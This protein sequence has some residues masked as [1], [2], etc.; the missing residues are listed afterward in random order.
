MQDK[1]R[2]AFYLILTI[3]FIIVGRALIVWRYGSLVRDYEA[4]KFAILK[5]IGNFCAIDLNGI[6]NILI[7]AEDHRHRY[8]FGIDFVGVLRAFKVKFLTGRSQGASTIDQQFVRAITG[9]RERN[10]RRKVREQLLAALIR[11][12]FSREDLVQAYIRN[13]YYGEGYVGEKGVLDLLKKGVSEYELVSYI[14]F[15]LPSRESATHESKIARRVA[16]ILSIESRRVRLI[17][18]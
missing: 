14:K 15:P 11:C 13:A 10:I 9:R 4:C 16:H 18:R 6:S 12:R 17:W 5:S 8:H 3:P 1:A 2:T 7:V